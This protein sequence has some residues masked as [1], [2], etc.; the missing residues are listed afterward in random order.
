[1]GTMCCK[2][3]INFGSHSAPLH[4]T[5]F[6]C[7]IWILSLPAGIVIKITDSKCQASTSLLATESLL[8][9]L[10]LTYETEPPLFSVVLF[11]LLIQQLSPSELILFKICLALD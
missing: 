7:K 5:F 2:I 3:F 4:Y 9:R 10:S 1:M 6:I 8:Q 11:L